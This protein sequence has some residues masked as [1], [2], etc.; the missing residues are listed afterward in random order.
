MVGGSDV[1]NDH[2]AEFF[3]PPHLAA[4]PRP[5]IIWAPNSATWGQQVPVQYSTVDPVNRAILIR[6]GSATHSQGF[7]ELTVR[8]LSGGTVCDA[9]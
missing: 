2:T 1:T 3:Y 7:G 9:A 8:Q 4:G 5:K 6:T